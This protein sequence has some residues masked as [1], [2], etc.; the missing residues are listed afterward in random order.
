MILGHEEVREKAKLALKGMHDLALSIQTSTAVRATADIVIGTMNAF[1]AVAN[2][3]GAVGPFISFFMDIFI[4][5]DEVIL[6][7]LHKIEAQ[8]ERLRGDMQY[9]FSK[10]I[11]EEK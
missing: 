6:E 1:K 7:E 8:I 2:F 9:F 4:D 5:K 10:V 3:L 11:N